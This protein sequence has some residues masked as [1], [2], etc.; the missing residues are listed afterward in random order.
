MRLDKLLAN[1]GYGSRKEIKKICRTGMVTVDGKPVKD[2]SMHVDPEVQ[3]VEIE[4]ERVI[5]REFVYLMMN[6]PDGVISATEDMLEETVVDLLD[7]YYY[8][9]EVFPVGRLDKDTEGLLVLTND[10]KLAHELLSPKKHVPKR[11]YAQVRGVVTEKDGE[12]FKRGVVLDDGYHTMPAQL[13]ILESGDVSEIE[14][15][16]YE[17]K[18]HQVK[19]MFEAVGK[20]VVYLKRL[21][22]GELELDPELEPGEYRELTEEELLLLRP[23]AAVKDVE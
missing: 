15:V 11:Y 5:Y 12:A 10:G 17:G 6:K 9:F 4:G 23:S 7:E 18:Y 1:M 22:M 14:L 13:T 2:S 8:N 20:K 21:A 16:I 3:V 19:R